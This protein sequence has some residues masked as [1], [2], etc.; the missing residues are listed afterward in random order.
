MLHRFLDRVVELASVRHARGPE[1]FLAAS[2]ELAEE[3]R[4]LRKYRTDRILTERLE[5]FADK[6]FDLVDEASEYAL[7]SDDVL[8]LSMALGDAANLALPALKRAVQRASS[9]LTEEG[10]PKAFGQLLRRARQLARQHGDSE[11]EAWVAG[12]I[13]ALPGD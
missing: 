11:L 1:A 8:I 5:A 2:G 10:M 13:G 12:V 7:A 9:V 4:L 6:R 3:F